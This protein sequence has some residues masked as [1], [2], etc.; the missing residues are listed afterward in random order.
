MLK[1]SLYDYLDAY[2]LVKGTR[3]VGTSAVADPNSNNVNTKIA[4]RNCAPLIDCINEINNTQVDSVKDIDLVML[5]Y[6]LI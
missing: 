1:S 2:I 4:F 6:K 5:M 3:S